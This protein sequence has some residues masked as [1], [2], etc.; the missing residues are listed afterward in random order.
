MKQVSIINIL[1]LVAVAIILMAPHAGQAQTTTRIDYGGEPCYAWG[2][3]GG[4]TTQGQFIR[5]Q[6]T[7]VIVQTTVT[8]TEVREVK[9]PVP[10][11]GPVKI[12]RVEVPAPVKEK[13]I[14]E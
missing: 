1:A 10:V 11:P 2:G 5:C 4:A 14:R 8:K 3:A 13:P 7:T 9:V 12:E 6:P